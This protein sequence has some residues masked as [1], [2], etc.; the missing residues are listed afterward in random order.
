MKP[1]EDF[2]RDIVP[3]IFPTMAEHCGRQFEAMHLCDD[4]LLSRNV[5]EYGLKFFHGDKYIHENGLQ[6]LHTFWHNY[7][8]SH[9]VKLEQMRTTLRSWGLI[10]ADDDPLF[11]DGNK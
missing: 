11:T 7:N 4:Y 9:D 3:N 10:P 2:L 8:V 5:A 6:H 1:H